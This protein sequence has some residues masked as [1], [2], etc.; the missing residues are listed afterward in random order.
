MIDRSIVTNPGAPI[1]QVFMVHETESNVTQ[2]W[3]LS[4]STLA[5][6]YSILHEAKQF[7]RVPRRGEP[8]HDD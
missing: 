8:V 2:K 5:V 6:F 1:T 7:L 4:R 3:Q